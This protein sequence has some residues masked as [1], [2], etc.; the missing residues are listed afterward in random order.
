MARFDADDD[1]D[2][3]EGAFFPPKGDSLEK[4]RPS[5]DELGGTSGAGG[6]ES[7]SISSCKDPV[8]SLFVRLASMGG[9]YRSGAFRSRVLCRGGCIF[10]HTSEVTAN[11]N[12]N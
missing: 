3:D 5:I 11:K 4:T 8:G 12:N 7:V 2:D 6:L 10:L 1:D 9:V